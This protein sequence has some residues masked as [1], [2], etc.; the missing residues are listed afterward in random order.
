MKNLNDIIRQNKVIVFLSLFLLALLAR[1]G[2][3]ALSTS[4]NG[5]NLQDFSANRSITKQVLQANRGTIYDRNGE[6]LAIDVSSYTVIAYLDEKRTDNPNKP[7]HV[8]DKEDTAKKLAK[9]LG[10]DYKT[11]LKILSKKDLYQVELGSVGRGITE[12]K[13]EEIEELNLPGIDFMPS[14]KRYYPNGIFA[15]YMIGY[16]KTDENGDIIGEFGIELE[17]DDILKGTNG[18]KEFQRDTKGYKIPDTPFIEENPI[19]GSDIYLTLDSNIQMFIEKALAESYKKYSMDWI[20]MTVADAKTGEILGSSG[21]PTYNPN[22]RDI[23]IYRNPL[24]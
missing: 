2:F 11:I 18:Y 14:Y 12:L 15:S 5:I 7:E 10:G 24:I 22:L 19:D 4:V 3:L 9:V 8:V 6:I 17:Y 20:H 23:E 13:K 16:A 21:Y 1:G